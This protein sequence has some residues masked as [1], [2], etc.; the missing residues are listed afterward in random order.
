MYAAVKCATE[1]RDRIAAVYNLD[2]AYRT[3]IKRCLRLI[4]KESK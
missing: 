4:I 2:G 3:Y 1:V